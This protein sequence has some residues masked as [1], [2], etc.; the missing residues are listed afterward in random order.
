MVRMAK[1]SGL[2]RRVGG[3]ARAEASLNNSIAGAYWAVCIAPHY[4]LDFFFPRYF[5]LLSWFSHY[6]LHSSLIYLCF[7]FI[8][9]AINSYYSF[10]SVLTFLYDPL[11]KPFIDLSHTHTEEGSPAR[12]AN[13]LGGLD[14]DELSGVIDDESHLRKWKWWDCIRNNTDKTRLYLSVIWRFAYTHL[15]KW[16]IHIYWN[17]I[18]KNYYN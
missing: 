17:K 11:T 16:D 4:Y 2:K 5:N 13:M 8:V 6:F 12:A 15:H 3:L 18:M 1:P 7:I 14:E 9:R 10:C